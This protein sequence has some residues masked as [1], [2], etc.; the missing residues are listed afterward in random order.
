MIVIIIINVVV[1]VLLCLNFYDKEIAL[2]EV[3]LWILLTRVNGW[4][5]TGI[6]VTASLLKLPGLFKVFE[7]ILLMQIVEII[8]LKVCVDGTFFA[9]T[10][11]SGL[12]TWPELTP[13]LMLK[14]EIGNSAFFAFFFFFFFFEK[15]LERADFS[16]RSSAL[17]RW[18][19]CGMKKFSSE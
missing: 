16:K 11:G 8:I 5:F 18:K 12:V 1:V 10:G 14:Q 19:P 2:L 17:D 13:F 15:S 3:N 7:P 9:V 4:S 6:W